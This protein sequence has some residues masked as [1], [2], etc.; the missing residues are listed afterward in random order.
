MLIISVLEKVEVLR[1]ET[2]VWKLE[3]I[4]HI[5]HKGQTCVGLPEQGKGFVAATSDERH[6]NA[7][8]PNLITVQTAN[9]TYGLS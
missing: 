5:I 1:S 4:P 7:L 8:S 6:M 3:I 9:G 2:S